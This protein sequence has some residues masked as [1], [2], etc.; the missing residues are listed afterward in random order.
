MRIGATFAVRPSICQALANDALGELIG[1]GSIINTK[2][3]AVAM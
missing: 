2:R 1:T 3:A